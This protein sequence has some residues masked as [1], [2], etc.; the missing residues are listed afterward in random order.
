MRIVSD[1]LFP[2]DPCRAKLHLFM[3]TYPN[4]AEVTEEACLA[5][6]FT[7]SD[8][9]WA[10]KKLFPGN[11]YNYREERSQMI[12]ECSRRLGESGGKEPCT[13]RDDAAKL[14]AKYA[15]RGSIT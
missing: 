15:A 2:H 3:E 7:D 8:F 9:D 12:T 10:M 13:C 4:G 11:Y 14:F 6:P 5:S 1:M